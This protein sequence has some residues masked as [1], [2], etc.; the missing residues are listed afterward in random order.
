MAVVTFGGGVSQK[1]NKEGDI[2]YARTHGGDYS[3][4]W[5]KPPDYNTPAQQY[6]R[7]SYRI[8]FQQWSALLTDQ[9]RTAWD[10]LG[11]QNPWPGERRKKGPLSGWQMFLKVNMWWLFQTGTT[12]LD[13]PPAVNPPV[14]TD[15]HITSL[16]VT[17]QMLFFRWTIKPAPGNLLSIFASG[18]LAAGRRYF[19]QKL[20]WIKTL[21]DADA[22]P[23]DLSAE[24]AAVW[25][26]IPPNKR[27]GLSC[28]P[29]DGTWYIAG[30][31]Q[32]TSK[33]SIP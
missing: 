33:V 16:T 5:F 15:V 14:V 9:Q 28:Q 3:R 31:R 26:A 1:R 24:Y 7:D 22:S 6:V 8:A 2:V 13:P 23:I 19:L 21:T 20:Q 4:A 27:I 29:L 17:P 12:T 10:E 32:L 11:R 18:P 30:I 25:G